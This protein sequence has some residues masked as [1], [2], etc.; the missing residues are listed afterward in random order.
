MKISEVHPESQGLQNIQQAGRATPAEKSPS[1]QEVKTPP[2]AEDKIDLS[3]RAKEM[4]KIHGIL[5]TTPEVRAERV[6][7]LKDLVQSGE[8][9]V[10]SDALADKMLK[11]SLFELNR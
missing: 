4:K 5:E 7:A 3:V 8:Y 6:A 10:Q 1:P 11:E 9:R 2:S